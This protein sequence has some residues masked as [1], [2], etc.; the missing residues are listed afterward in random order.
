M[1]PECVFPTFDVLQKEI[2][3]RD[4]VADLA[5]KERLEFFFIGL[6]FLLELFGTSLD[7]TK[8]KLMRVLPLGAREVT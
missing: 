8:S 6:E 1:D 4:F 2:F 5:S 3:F 7:F